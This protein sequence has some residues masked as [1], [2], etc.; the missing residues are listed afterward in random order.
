[1]VDFTKKEIEEFEQ[2]TKKLEAPLTMDD[3]NYQGPLL[4]DGKTVKLT[5]YSRGGG[6]PLQVAGDDV[7]AFWISPGEFRMG[8]PDFDLMSGI[9]TSDT[10][11]AHKFTKEDIDT[12][13]EQWIRG[14]SAPLTMDDYNY[15][16]P[17]LIDGK[18][19][20]PTGYSRGGMRPLEVEDRDG[21]TYWISPS[22]F[23]L[24]KDT[25]EGEQ[26][27]KNAPLASAPTATDDK[28]LDYS[29]ATVSSVRHC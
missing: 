27:N 28:T 13:V 25:F 19:V 3:Y 12:K 16:G 23:R 22:E 2:L 15:K 1:M 7:K 26:Q 9:R 29:K 8:K 10:G 11:A 5:G 18:T 6:Q 20:T 4:I 17:L 21:N 14:L 24:G